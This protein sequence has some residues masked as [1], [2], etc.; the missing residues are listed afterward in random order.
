MVEVAGSR[1]AGPFAW[2]YAYALEMSPDALIIT[3]RIALDEPMASPPWGG[4]GW[5]WEIENIWNGKAGVRTGDGRTLP[6]VVDVVF[7]DVAP[8]HSVDVVNGQAGKTHMDTW[9]VATMDERVAA[10][11]VGHMLGLPDEYPGGATITIRS[12]TLMGGGAHS[13]MPVDYYAGFVDQARLHFDPSLMLIDAPPEP[14]LVAEDV[15]LK[16]T[17]GRDT[18]IGGLGDDCLIGR[19]G[20]DVL[21]G[22]DGADVLKGGKGK[23]ILIGGPGPDTFVVKGR[24]SLPD[25]E[26]GLDLI[27]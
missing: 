2:T 10:H 17:K 3:V 4:P 14:A 9:F 5:E 7:T 25:Y 20:K 27:I 19:K 1:Q 15:I 22:A 8:H 11:E 21:E 23:D 24:D 26:P 12:G 18:L 16:G 6:I 13:E